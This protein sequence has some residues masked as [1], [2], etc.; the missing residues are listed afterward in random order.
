MLTQ[1]VICLGLLITVG[2]F[3]A[4]DCI[5]KDFM[6]KAFEKFEFGED[7][8]RRVSVLMRDSKSCV[9]YCGWFSNVFV[10]DSGIWHR[11]P[12]S[13]PAFVL[14]VELLAIKIRDCKGIKGITLLDVVNGTDLAQVLKIVLYADDITLFWGN[15]YEMSHA[16]SIMKFVSCVSGLEVNKQNSEDMWL[17]LKKH[18]TDTFYNFVWKRNW[19]FLEFTFAMICVHPIYWTIG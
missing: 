19:R 18:C 6:L 4:I 16:L 8:I 9:N 1:T 11:C 7:F 13:L 5:S 12:F 17:G 3:H 14:L 10:V 15:E 2:Y